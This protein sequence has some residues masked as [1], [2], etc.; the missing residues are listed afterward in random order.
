[1]TSLYLA[2][3]GES[4]LNVAGVYF[5]VTDCHLTQKGENQ[6][7]ELG[8]KLS[9][10]DFDIIITSPLKRAF[11]SAEL[12]GNASKEDIIVMK[13]L[14]ELNFGAWEGMHYKDIEKEYNSKWKEWTKDWKNVS[15]PKG[16]SFKEFY[17]RVK[18]I[19]ENILSKYK[20]KKILVVCHQGTL[21]VIASVLLDMGTNGYW[22]FAF[23]Y[24]KY[25]LFEITD[26]FAVL[27]KING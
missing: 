2:R 9:D 25:S 27:K 5:G 26:G 13:D 24:G 1:M 6:C 4:E 23:D 10:I 8:E 19:L 17:N 20:D 16:E 21:K 14:M 12:I 22:R 18:I 3:H 15:P 7:I 11:H